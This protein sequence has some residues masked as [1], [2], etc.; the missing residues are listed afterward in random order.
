MSS[1]SAKQ[2]N[3]IVIMTDDQGYGDM[4]CHGNPW[5]KTPNLDRLAAESIQLEDYHVDPVCTPTRAALMTGRYSSRVGAWTVTEGRQLLNSDEV[6]MADVF[7]ASGYRTG[8]FG[9]WHLGDSWPYA[10]GAR[11]FQEVV[12]HQAGGVD[13]IGNPAGNDFFDDT[14]YHNGQPKKFRG[15]CTDV[16]FREAMRFIRQPGSGDAGKPFFVYLALNAMHGPFTVAEEYSA[17]FAAQG[18]AEKRAKFYGMIANFDENLGRLL[19]SL[20]QWD[21]ERDTLVIFMG[22]NGSAAGAAS[23][24][25]SNAGF[26][27]GMRGKK[28]SVYD[29]G[30]RVACF[31]RWPGKLKAGHAVHQITSHRDW[32]PTLIDL[33]GLKIPGDVAFDGQSIAP[34]LVQQATDW[35]DRTLFIERQGDRPELTRNPAARNRYPQYTVLTEKWRLVSGKLYDIVAD[36]GQQRDVTSSNSTVADELFAAYEKHFADVYPQDSAYTRFQIGSANENRTGFTV[37]DWHPTDGNVIWKSEQLDDDDLFING[38]WPVEILS[39]GRYA[40][41]LSRFPQDVSAP[42]GANRARLQMSDIDRTLKIHPGDSSVTFEVE[43]T[44]GRALLQTWL[45]DA[46]S[47][48]QRGAYFVTFERRP[49][50][51]AVPFPAVIPQVKPTDRPLSVAMQRLYDVWNPHEDRGNELYSNFK[52]SPLKGLSYEGNISRRDPSKVLKIDGTYYVW[53][54]RRDT[55]HPPSGPQQANKVTP[56][57]DWDLCEIWYATSKDGFTW[58]EQRPAI[59]RP[60]KGEYGWRS[61]STP[62]ILAWGGRFYLYYQGFNEIPGLKGDR[63]AT[64]VAEADSPVGPWRPL[65]R[66]VVDFGAEGEWDS[67][68]IHDPYP[69]VYRGR[70]YLYYKG[71][72]GRHG[73]DG[74]LVRAQG[75]AIADHPKGPF[76]K[77]PL[78]PVTSSGHETCFFP[79]KDGVAAIVSLDGPEKNTVQFAPDGINFEVKSLL[80]IPPIA[81]GAFVPDAFADNGNGRGIVWGLCHINPDGGAANAHSILARFDCDLSREV[82]RRAMKNNNLRF[83]QQ[84]YFQKRVRLPEYLDRQIRRERNKLDTD[85]VMYRSDSVAG[86]RSRKTSGIVS[87]GDRILATPATAA[88]TKAFPAVMPWEKPADR[89]LSAAW[90][91]MWDRWNPHEDRGNELYSNFK[92]TPLEGLKHEPNVSRRDPTKVIRLGGKYYVWYTCRRTTTA[93]VGVEKATETIPAT[94]WDLAD[95]WYA[96]SDDGYTWTEQGVAV[97]RPENPIQGF[98]SICTPDIL[99]WKGKYYLYFQAYSPMVGRTAYCPVMAAVADSPDGP[100]TLHEE[101]VIE[102]GPEGSW[103]NIKINDPCLLV[104]N[105]RI[106]MYYKGAPREQGDEYVLRMQGVSFADHPLGPFVPSKLNPVINSGHETC[107]WPWKGGVA[108]LVA[109]DGPEKNTIQFAPDGENFEVMSIIQVPP[110][111]PGPF[112][113]DA[114]ASDGDG[115]G[116]TWGLSHINPDGGGATSESILV[117]FDCDLSLNVDRPVFKRNNLRFEQST[118][119]QARVRLPDFMRRQIDEERDR[120]DRDTIQPAADNARP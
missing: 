105:D 92:Y 40:I 76:I 36:P 73:E 62:D 42:M 33:C 17:P 114:F 4:A 110:I 78:N 12:C 59:R 87:T 47:G 18:H 84:T 44:R 25:E 5:L 41:H 30:H 29:G 43:L 111:A 64:T 81:P 109:L 38:F 98:R 79:W 31:V 48:R 23:A 32:L 46:G 53:Y 118:Y 54:T 89:I 39:S 60:A 106:L 20:K 66:V 83:D 28:G 63:A 9:K 107:M 94:D 6:T 91:R 15:Y 95:I 56:S 103:N 58:E 57:F 34:L 82:D 55:E 108:A 27:A 112:V 102:P 101:P 74:T 72:P 7:A 37:R 45:T 52:Y 3:V 8:M 1:S 104:V 67:N 61:V 26:N 13:E 77:S 100:W 22:D 21:L 85:T 65:G 86:S 80:Q 119:F 90:A 120:V 51:K 116:I 19:E 14:Y 10:P 11:G 97:K 16:F 50:R 75:V 113:P 24:D 93:P 69:I 88:P 70:I 49:A 96:T 115:R 68:A 71:S 35:P 2:P 99:L 117:R